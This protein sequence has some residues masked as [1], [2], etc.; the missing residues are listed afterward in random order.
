MG[1]QYELWL[2]RWPMLYVMAGLCLFGIV[3]KIIA[4]VGCR[5]LSVQ[6]RRLSMGKP[7]VKH[8]LTKSLIERYQGYIK[9]GQNEIDV[10]HYLEEGLAGARVCGFNMF[11]LENLNLTMMVVCFTLGV[12]GAMIAFLNGSRDNEIVF[13][14]T[15]GLALT[16]INVVAEVLFRNDYHRMYYLL[17]MQNYLTNVVRYREQ[18]ELLENEELERAKLERKQK[19]GKERKKDKKQLTAQVTKEEKEQ[20]TAQVTK[21]EKEQ[22]GLIREVEEQPKDVVTSIKS[23]QGQLLTEIAKARQLSGERKRTAEQD[24]DQDKEF[25]YRDSTPAGIAATKEAVFGKA[26]TVKAEQKSVASDEVHAKAGKTEIDNELLE[27]I[28]RSLLMEN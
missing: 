19:L 12:I 20:L 1:Y 11:Q 8:K 5:G 23:K 3:T 13:I 28:L 14:F 21:E 26:P 16:G 18:E 10:E 4:S 2:S 27:D 6:I 22:L 7:V 24:D 25:T 15:A 17:G 9:K